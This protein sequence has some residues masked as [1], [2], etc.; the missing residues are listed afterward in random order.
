MPSPRVNDTTGE[1]R[2]LSVDVGDM[3][4]LDVGDVGGVDVVDA[5]MPGI[6]PAALEEEGGQQGQ[7]QPVVE[8]LPAD[9][10]TTETAP[11]PLDV[12]AES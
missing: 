3:G 9:A 8:T 7:Q 10:L 4:G 2:N 5:P 11:A 12:K 6:M 1:P